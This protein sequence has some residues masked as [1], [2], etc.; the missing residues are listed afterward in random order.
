M[1][2]SNLQL[3]MTRVTYLKR[4][5]ISA[6]PVILSVLRNTLRGVK[7]KHI[8]LTQGKQAIVDDED[9]EMLSKYKWHAQRNNR[10]WYALRHEWNGG[11]KKAFGMHRVVMNAPVGKQVDH[12]N[13]NGLDNRKINLRLCTATQN[14]ANRLKPLGGKSKYKGVSLTRCGWDA[15]IECKGKRYYLGSFK[16]EVDAAKAYDKAACELFGEF[17]CLNFPDCQ[18]DKNKLTQ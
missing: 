13:H 12:I 16:D 17:A 9:F 8:E 15:K 5:D 1:I 10:A 4:M 7:M 14:K 6:I 2:A 11:N 18:S 3:R